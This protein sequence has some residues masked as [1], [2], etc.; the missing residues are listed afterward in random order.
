MTNK[1]KK[2]LCTIVGAGEGLG[3]SLAR[4]FAQQGFDI[5]LISRSESTAAP[6]IDSLQKSFSTVTA[7]Y[8]AAD[9]TQ[10][11]EL[12][13]VISELHREMGNTTILLYNA[14][15][16]F[17]AYDPLDLP[18]EVLDNLLRIEVVGALAAA[19][20][21]LPAMIEKGS[22]NVFYSSATAAFRGSSQYPHYAIAKFGLRALSQSLSRAY[23]KQGIHIAHMR[24]DCDLD[25]P[26][27]QSIY[28]DSDHAPVMVNPDDVAESY[29]LT[30]LQPKTAWSNEVELRPF[31]ETWTC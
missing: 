15:G 10:P 7:R 5:A 12:E 8:F 16:E 2:A 6:I 13:A 4:K 11:T 23:S 3:K 26:L 17:N 27:M 24:L 9:V 22:G 21:V 14:R 31:T 18:Y 19:K 30:Y 29:W 1:S 28:T 25:V 20:A